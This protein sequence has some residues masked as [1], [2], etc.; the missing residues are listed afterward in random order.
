MNYRETLQAGLSIIDLN[1]KSKAGDNA[2]HDTMIMVIVA[3]AA[4][5]DIKA[6]KDGNL[7][8]VI[9]ACIPPSHMA[10]VRARLV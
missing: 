10:A 2:A 1:D 7:M 4:L 9:E 6:I 8:P 5:G 3:V